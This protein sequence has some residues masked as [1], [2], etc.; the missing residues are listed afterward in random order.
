MNR[1][2]LSPERKKELLKEIKAFFYEERDEEIGD[3][4]ATLFL[5]FIMEKAAPIIYNQAISDAY[6]FMSDKL[7]DLY[8]LE[9]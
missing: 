1:D 9:K 2:D 6:R 4:A 5:E 3:L 8:G 7:E